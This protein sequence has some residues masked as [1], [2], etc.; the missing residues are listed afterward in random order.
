MKIVFFGTPTIA[1][2]VLQSLI[3][4]HLDIV[5]A[6]TK[7]DK[8]KGRSGVPQP[9]PVKIVAEKYTIPLLQPEQISTEEN[10]A[11]IRHLK[12]DLFV[13]V[14][15]GELLKKNILEIPRYGAINLHGSLL[16]KYRG[17]APIQRALLEGEK[18][19]GVSIIRM[20]SKMDAGPILLKKKVPITEEMNAV[21]LLRAVSRAGI[22][23][24]LETIPLIEKGAVVEEIQEESRV[25][26][27]PKITKEEEALSCDLTA[28]QIDRRIKGLYPYAYF[29]VVLR[30]EKVK[31][32]CLDS[33]IVDLPLNKGEILGNKER[34]IFGTSSGSIEIL[35]LK[36]EG[37]KELAA[38]EWLKSSFSQFSLFF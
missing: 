36:Q 3:D 1:A 8:P 37:R 21:Q 29:T 38:S 25:T 26:F 7:P 15:F 11:Q 34:F 12:P 35:R 14:A 10:A 13:V 16:P 28:F 31:L 5:M 6:V 33:K 9:P 27:A 32:F 30:G 2:E 23:A 20:V 18:E 22:E 24:L 17:A 4:A 19:T